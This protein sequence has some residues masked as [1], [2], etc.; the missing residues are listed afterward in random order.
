[1]PPMAGPRLPEPDLLALDARLRQLLA[2]ITAGAAAY[3]EVAA[4]VREALGSA[5]RQLVN[6][7]RE[8]EQGRWDWEGEWRN[9][10]RLTWARFGD[11]REPAWAALHAAFTE[12]VRFVL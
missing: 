4:L 3:E 12:M 11:S 10:G 7:G 9:L 8:K 1:M 6:E 2:T 5:E